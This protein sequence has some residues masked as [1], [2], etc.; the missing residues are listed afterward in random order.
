MYSL[1]RSSRT[2]SVNIWP[3]FVDGLA[4]LLLVVIFVLMVFM[5]AQYFLSV[6][7]SGRDQQLDKMGRELDELG[8]LL[9]LER[10]ANA[11]LR[12]NIAQLSSELQTSLEARDELQAELRSLTEQRDRTAAELAAAEQARDS[13]ASQLAALRQQREN[14]E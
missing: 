10:D 6:A 13:L 5:V 12:I 4:T 9:I 2:R 11:D 1:S 8:R 14:N 7:L 3:G